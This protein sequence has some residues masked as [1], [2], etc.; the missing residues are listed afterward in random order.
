MTIVESCFWGR[1]KFKSQVVEEVTIVQE[2]LD[3]LITIT[4][5][6]SL[7]TNGDEEKKKPG[8]SSSS[9]KQLLLIK[10]LNQGEPLIEG[11]EDVAVVVVV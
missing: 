4:D 10:P 8:A 5:D 2:H 6:I 3:T 1:K 9:L 7:L 11:V